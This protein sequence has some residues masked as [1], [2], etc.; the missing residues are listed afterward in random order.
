MAKQLPQAQLNND[1]NNPF[2]DTGHMCQI[3]DLNQSKYG[4]GWRLVDYKLG[5]IHGLP[6]SRGRICASDG[7]SCVIITESGFYIGHH[8]W[9]KVEKEPREHK[10]R[11][12]TAKE[13]STKGSIKKAAILTELN[14]LL[15]L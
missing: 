1:I 6:Q 8:A 10:I 7:I 11:I 4:L 13:T 15:D 9:F 3:L 12:D 5:A 14:A 2:R